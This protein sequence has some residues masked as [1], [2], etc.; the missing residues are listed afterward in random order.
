MC[1]AQERPQRRHRAAYLAPSAGQ[2]HQQQQRRR[3]QAPPLN[4]EQAGFYFDDSLGD[5]GIPL[6]LEVPQNSVTVSPPSSADG[7]SDE[8]REQ[9]QASLYAPRKGFREHVMDAMSGMYNGFVDFFLLIVVCFMGCFFYDVEVKVVQ[10]DRHRA[11]ARGRRGRVVIRTED[12]PEPTYGVMTN[13]L[14]T[15]PRSGS[16][17]RASHSDPRWEHVV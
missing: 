9:M 11:R 2:W 5:L 7:S 12:P 4:I 14:R 13:L 1:P 8:F 15:P 6:M 16:F 17:S 10:S 3:Q